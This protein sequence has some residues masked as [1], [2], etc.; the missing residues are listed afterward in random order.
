METLVQRFM[1]Y[2]RAE[3]N[4]SA[5]TIRA[6]DH[7][8][9][10]FSQFLKEKYQNLSLDSSHRIVIRDF[11]AHLYDCKLDCSTIVR[12]VAVLRSFYR[13]LMQEGLVVQTPFVGLPL[14]KRPERLPK[15]LAEDEMSRLLEF[16]GQSPRRNAKRDAALLELLYSSG[17]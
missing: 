1:L 6:Y 5:H 10:A 13:Y 4:A 8:L 9:A 2:L 17:L 7:D 15:Y 12:K 16:S 11:L 14:P 3:R